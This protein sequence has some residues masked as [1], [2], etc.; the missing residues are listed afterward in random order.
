MGS[1]GKRELGNRV[2][3][4]G[5]G[6]RGDFP[7]ARPCPLL[8]PAG[9]EGGEEDVSLCWSTILNTILLQGF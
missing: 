2:L 6:G 9:G 8:M 7:R 5:E 1:D 4:L 3:F